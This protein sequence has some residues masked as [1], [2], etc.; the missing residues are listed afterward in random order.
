MDEYV[1]VFLEFFFKV[2]GKFKKFIKE[3]S[4]IHF[5]CVTKF[6]EIMYLKENI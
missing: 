4:T 6:V 3:I 5:F 2:F 1:V